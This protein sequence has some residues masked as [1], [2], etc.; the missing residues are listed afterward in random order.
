M[1]RSRVIGKIRALYVFPDPAIYPRLGIQIG[2]TLYEHGPSAQ[3][4]QLEE[5]AEYELRG[6]SGELRLAEHGPII[7]TMV[8][9]ERPRP[10]RSHPYPHEHQLKLS[11]DLDHQR[12]EA[13]ERLRS[14]NPP[15]LSLH[16]WPT[17]VRSGEL[18]EGEIRAIPLRIDRES[19]LE[20][21]SRSRSD[22]YEVIE[23]RFRTDEASAFRSALQH[24]RVA[25]SKIDSGDSKA[26]V[27]ACRLALDAIIDEHPN[28]PKGQRQEQTK[29]LWALAEERAHPGSVEQYRTM[30]SKLYSLTSASH[31]NYG[32]NVSFQ[33]S[34]ALFTVR[35]TEG[36]LALLGELTADD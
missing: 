8:W 13:I 21:L 14:G 27:G 25:R 15:L 22:Q 20:F 32:A 24:V 9:G 36:F 19:W 16:L 6:I 29:A 10:L 11:C 17:L 18:L 1:Y 3:Y 5:L 2:C 35:M 28:I 30:F 33:R 26:A 23:V 12:I 34:E 31:H 7:G 4:P